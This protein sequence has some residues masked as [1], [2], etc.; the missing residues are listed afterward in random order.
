MIYASSPDRGL[1]CLLKMFPIIKKRIPKA[2]LDVFYGWHVWDNMYANDPERMREKEEIMSLME[3]DGVVFHGRVG[4]KDIL[5]EYAKSSILAYPSEFTEI[6]FIGGMKAQ[7][8]GAIPITTNVAA[9]N[10]TIQFGLK[11]DTDKIYT[12]EDAQYEFIEA[13]INLMENSPT[14]DDRKEMSNWARDKFNWDNVVR[15]WNEEFN[16]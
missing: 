13:I 16:N 1:K 4:Q 3:Q 2:Q 9:L 12:N 8:L 6:S 5:K 15:C 7:A 14:E 10:E 11:V